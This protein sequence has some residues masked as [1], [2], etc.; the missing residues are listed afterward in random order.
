MAP[1]V[2]ENNDKYSG[3]EI[4]S[5]VSL[6]MFGQFEQIEYGTPM[7][8][9]IIPNKAPSFQNAFGSAWDGIVGW[10]WGGDGGMG[11]WK[12]EILKKRNFW[13][14]FS[15]IIIRLTRKGSNTT[16]SKRSDILDVYDWF[17]LRWIIPI[18]I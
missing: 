2:L 8:I 10:V 5:D 12:M 16:V 13:K 7:V 1:N 17:L 6:W 3:F 18:W 9:E 11:G 15:K 4:K 14:I